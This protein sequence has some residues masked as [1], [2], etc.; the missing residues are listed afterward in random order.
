M[1]VCVRCADFCILYTYDY[2]V[3]IED[4]GDVSITYPNL[5]KKGNKG[6]CIDGDHDFYFLYTHPQLF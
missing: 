5:A 4:D 1:V 2:N 6:T 3:T